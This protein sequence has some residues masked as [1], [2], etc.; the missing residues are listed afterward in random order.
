MNS[1]NPDAI[2]VVHAKTQVK[3]RV[4]RTR[5]LIE[6]DRCLHELCVRR[7]MQFEFALLVTR[8]TRFVARARLSVRARF[9]RIFWRFSA[10]SKRALAL[11]RMTT[12]AHGGSRMHGTAWRT[13][14]SARPDSMYRSARLT[15]R[16]HH[17]SGIFRPREC[18]Y[19]ATLMGDEWAQ[20]PRPSERQGTS[21]TAARLSCASRPAPSERGAVF[22]APHS[23]PFHTR[24]AL[25]REL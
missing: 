6:F 24:F 19:S 21:S 8:A 1:P 15:M 9:A 5:A 22:G 7:A 12:T 11:E 23:E 20:A 10:R 17:H 2:G 16:A 3:V 25:W 13:A 14:W 18:G 4:L